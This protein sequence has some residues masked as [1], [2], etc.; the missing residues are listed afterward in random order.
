MALA[1]KSA[2]GEEEFYLL[3]GAVD[4][5]L[6]SLGSS[7]HWYDGTQ[8]LGIMNYELGIFPPHRVA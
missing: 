5:L 2:G 4:Q 6:E 7:E 1:K 8:E 3:K